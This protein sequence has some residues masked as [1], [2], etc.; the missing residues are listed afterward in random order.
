MR[1]TGGGVAHHCK[2][3][4]QVTKWDDPIRHPSLNAKRLVWGG[5]SPEINIGAIGGKELLH[6]VFSDSRFETTPDDDGVYAL[7]STME[8]LYP[9]ADF[10]RAQDAFGAGRFEVE[11]TVTSEEGSSAKALLIIHVDRN[12]MSLGA[13]KLMA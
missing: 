9:Q 4:L 8:S 13:E 1:N 12:Y 7:V 11:V 3:E 2:A 5:P 10:V 6:V